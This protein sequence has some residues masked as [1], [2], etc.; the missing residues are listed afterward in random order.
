M[1]DRYLSR[2]L[3]RVAPPRRL[4]VLTGARQV[5]KTTLARSLY[6]ESCRYLNLDSPGERG[7][8]AAIPAEGWGRAV[9]PAVLDEVQKA[10]AL[11]DCLKWAYDE[12]QIDFS[13]LLG[14]S[15]ILL[16]DKVKESLAGRVFLYELWPLTVGELAP[17]FGGTV[18]DQP[19]IARLV[20]APGQVAGILAGQA[21]AAVGPAAG[22]AAAAMTHILSWGGLPPLLQYLEPERFDWLDAYQ[23]TYLE[24]DLGDLA[25]LRDLETFATCHRL[26][27]LRAALLL[28]YSD[29]ARDAGLPVTTVRR[30]LSYLDLSYQTLHLP[31]WS[32]NAGVR[33]V[34]APKLVWFDPGVQRSLSGQT[35]ELTGA[36]Y[37][38]AV[39]TQILITLWSLGVKVSA[40][41]LRTSAGLE[42]DLLLE[43][44]DRLIAVEIKA[45]PRVDRHDA[46]S[47]ER[48][49][50]HLG[51]RLVAG[52]VVYRG[53]ELGPL[54]DSV[55]AVPDWMLIGT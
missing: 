54:A 26:A 55:F 47:I 1:L 50:R 24:R 22:A 29:L 30:Y 51:D 27:A 42:V 12:G 16:L 19:L 11:L 37:E 31:P 20:N 52:L 36:Q 45:R 49:R 8:L 34:K 46:A 15:R 7:R 3:P 40:S 6:S 39:I 2:R 21:R 48:A 18:P 25:R 38:N 41:F 44:E 32:G 17:H 9:G 33:L 13:V 43:H 28:S 35:R 53:Q 4:V 5:G 14:S 23:S 10:P